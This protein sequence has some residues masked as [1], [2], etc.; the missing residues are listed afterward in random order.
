ML[1]GQQSCEVRKGDC[2]D[3]VY[4]AHAAHSG[5]G[6]NAGFVYGSL[7]LWCYVVP[8]ICKRYCCGECY[9]V[10][11]YHK[12]EG[13]GFGTNVLLLTCYLSPMLENVVLAQRLLLLV[14]YMLCL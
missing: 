11:L 13:C 10:V 6:L 8:V 9:Q 5:T 1:S 2:Q 7:I 4:S 12:K 14:V 3:K